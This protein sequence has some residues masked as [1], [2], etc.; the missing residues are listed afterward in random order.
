[1]ER[2]R[3]KERRW[4]LS[5]LFK[6]DSPFW[7]F[8][9]TIYN[10]RGITKRFPRSHQSTYPL[11]SL[12]GD[13]VTIWFLRGTRLLLFEAPGL[14]S[15]GS[16]A[17][18]WLYFHNNI[19]PTIN[20]LHTFS[21]IF[22]ALWWIWA[23]AK[24]RRVCNLLQGS[25]FSNRSQN[26]NPH[27][28]PIL[29]KSTGRITAEFL[30]LARVQKLQFAHHTNWYLSWCYLCRSSNISLGS[31][32]WPIKP[33]VINIHLSGAAADRHVTLTP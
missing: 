23:G 17:I 22:Y 27:A 6:S 13:V 15:F 9:S 25:H 14:K 7:I 32:S 2:Q 29:R 30:G 11:V 5:A 12:T 8:Q 19:T 3:D 4:T 33:D 20:F 16:S 21:T 26:R 24:K 18:S 1:M 31:S 28:R 10:T